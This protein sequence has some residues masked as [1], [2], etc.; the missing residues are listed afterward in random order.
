MMTPARLVRPTVGLIPTTEL[1]LDGHMM[2]PSVSVP[3]VTA[4]MFA[5]AA[6][7]E[8]LLEEHVVADGTYGFY[9]GNAIRVVQSHNSPLLR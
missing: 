5:A 1:K 8:P 3:I 9:I 7:A 6:M 2:D 4:A